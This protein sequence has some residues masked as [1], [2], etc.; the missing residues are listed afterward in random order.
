MLVTPSPAPARAATGTR[1]TRGLLSAGAAGA[2]GTVVL[3][4][5]Q[6][7]VRPGYD[8]IRHYVSQLSLGPGGWV[9]VGNFLATGILMICFALGLRSALRAGPGAVWGPILVATFGVGLVVAAIFPADP[10]LGGYPPGSV[11]PA[12]SPT[13]A[14]RVHILGAVVVFTSLSAACLVLARRFRRNPAWRGWAAYSVVTGVVVWV[15]WAG[16]TVLSG[17]GSAP[18]DAVV[19]LVQRVYLLIGFTWIALVALRMRRTYVG[20]L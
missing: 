10:G 5:A 20:R 1:L 13:V 2:V 9:Q 11:I 4:V 8:P 19:G 18:I 14:F 3:F 12:D 17:D 6:G 16:S 15:M 7:A